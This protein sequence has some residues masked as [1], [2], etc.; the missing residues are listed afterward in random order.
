MSTL[1][2]SYG[3]GT[4]AIHHGEGTDALHAHLHPIYMT[5]TFSFADVDSGTAVMTGQAP[6]YAYT[7]AGNPTNEH[8]AAKYALLEGLDLVR[9]NPQSDPHTLV[10]AVPFASGM[11]AIS[12]GVLARVRAGQAVLVQRSLYNTAF[13]FFTEVVP[14]Y[15]IETVWVDDLSPGGWEASIRAHANASLLYIETPSNPAML[16]LDIPALCDVA[17]RHGLWVMADNTFATPY[18][19]RPLTLGVDMVAHSTTKY[20]AGHGSHLGGVVVSPHIEFVDEQVLL[21]LRNHGGVPSPMEC[22]LGNLGLKTFALRMERHCANGMAVARYLAAHPKVAG[23][24][25]PGLP[26]DPGHGTAQK[27]MPGGFGGMISFELKGGAEAGKALI[28]RLQ[29]ATLAA[30]LGNVDSLIQLSAVMNYSRLSAADRARMNIPDGLIR[31]STGIED[32]ADVLDDF[33][34]ALSTLPN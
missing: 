2:P 34:R 11:A 16:V 19:Q 1:P 22:W 25:Y 23:V 31:Y 14:R 15:G 30:S 7:R 21:M 10:R 8:L 28:A 9:A 3:L 13:N 12:S 18:C 32:T 27:Q 6:G 5:S 17:H 29:L 24:R 20:L 26:A 4:H 33:D